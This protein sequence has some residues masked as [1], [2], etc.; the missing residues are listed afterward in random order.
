MKSSYLF[1][2][3]RGVL[4]AS[5][6][7]LVSC[8]SPTGSSPSRPVSPAVKAKLRQPVAVVFVGLQDQISFQRPAGSRD[9]FL[10]SVGDSR[11]IWSDIAPVAAAAREGAVLLL[12]FLATALV[13]PPLTCLV[14][15]GATVSPARAEAAAQ[16]LR[17]QAPPKNWGDVVRRAV[18]GHW[19]ASGRSFSRV[20]TCDAGMLRLG[21]D[22]LGRETLAKAE[23]NT[24]LHLHVAGPAVTMEGDHVNPRIAPG[25]TIYWKVIDTR[26]GLGLAQGAICERSAL[27]KTLLQWA[28]DAEGGAGLQAELENA[29]QRASG[30][31][32]REL[33]ST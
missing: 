15:S 11:E 23:G 2:L 30:R 17:S 12:P 4:L 33:R 32:A 18:V 26:T 22:P 9:V 6:Y 24:L 31:L 7:C 29:V 13:V 27:R 25:I 21:Y 1:T 19:A 8:A 28:R 20:D 14:T 3:L 10:R 5:V 16:Q